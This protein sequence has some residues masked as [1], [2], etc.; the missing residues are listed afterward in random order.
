MK[1]PGKF[2]ITNFKSQCFLNIGLA[3]LSLFEI[4]YLLFVIWPVRFGKHARFIVAGTVV[5]LFATLLAV[6]V[7]AATISIPELKANAGVPPIDES[8]YGAILVVDTTSGK[9][10]YKLNPAKTWVPASL[11]KLMTA[12]VFTSTPTNWTA[13]GN[14][15]SVDEVGGG[16]LQVPSGSAMS[17]RDVLYSAIVG[18]ANN[19]AEALARMFDGEETSVF[20]QRMNDTA[21]EMGLAQT[22]YKDA[23]G[24]NPENTTSAYDTANVLL[25]AAEEA[26]TQTAMVTPYYKFATRSP[27]I[28]KNI[29]NTNDL[30]FTEPDM[31]V[32]AGKT[33]FLYESE[34]NYT[35]RVHPTSD[36]AKELVIVIL[37]AHTRADSVN[38]TVT[39]TNWVWNA[40]TWKAANAPV[41]LSKGYVV[42]DVGDEI[43]SLQKFLNANG[44]TIAA[45]GAGSPG[46]ETNYYGSLTKAAV[47]RFQNDQKEMLAEK[48]A[49]EGSGYLDLSTR[50]AIHSFASDAPVAAPP[51]SSQPSS[52]SASV[53]SLPPLGKGAIG[54]AV[55]TLQEFLAR[56]AE[57]YPEKLVT[58]YFGSLTER[59]VE[60]FQLKHGVVASASDLG[61]GYVG[62]KTRAKIAELY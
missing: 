22:S 20:I 15:L 3:R 13:T 44:Y 33:G 19:A 48:G 41:V 57:V 5:M 29:K 51:A 11:T 61:Y 24:M 12:H 25:A 43:R 36:P 10:L 4:C 2:Q 32:T 16:R 49:S 26:E 60:R 14:V 45:S 46:R 35:V 42:G 62:P 39:L 21:K 23:A 52:S 55:R 56:D 27:V 6:P 34:Y 31:V 58:G 37:G 54:T 47:K 50:F 7:H 1:T 59:A 8:A 40:F 9:T 17:L 53:I 28:Q 30:L 18:S 38:A